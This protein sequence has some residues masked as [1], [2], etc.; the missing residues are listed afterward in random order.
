MIHESFAETEKADQINF[1][2]FLDDLVD[3][4]DLKC[5]TEAK[6]LTIEKQISSIDLN[7]N[8]A[9]PTGLFCN[10]ILNEICIYSQKETREPR[11][12][13]TL[14]EKDEKVSLYILFNGD[15]KVFQKDESVV[16]NNQNFR[17]EIIETLQTQLKGDL[18]VYKRENDIYMKFHFQKN[19]NYGSSSSLKREKKLFKN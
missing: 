9:V 1:G 19:N 15:I 14:T 10:E 7:I 13:I 12:N 16:S 3:Y 17:S 18:D 4:I 5:S 2:D 8:Q 11:L 6:K